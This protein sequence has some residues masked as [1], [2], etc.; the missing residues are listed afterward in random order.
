LNALTRLWNDIITIIPNIVAAIIVLVVG[1][2]LA[3][4]LGRLVHRLI[5]FT[6]F[7]TFLEKAVGLNKLKE[8]GIN[9]TAAGLVSWTVKWFLIIVTFIAVADILQWDQ[10]TRF[11]EA[12]ALYIPNVIITVL[13]LLVGLILGGGLKELIIKTVKAST[14]PDASAG[15]LG[16]VAQTAV[17]VFAVM[18]A[19]TQLGIA[20]DL[21]KILF[22]GFVAMLALSGGLSFGLG[23]RDKAAEWLDKIHKEIQH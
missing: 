8:R 10:L 2:I 11:F 22:T 19:F 16:T 5:D 18:A 13:I 1:L 4:L 12:V 23:G 14:F 6:K 9:V 17:I 3:G 21:I 15:L 7:D 20:E